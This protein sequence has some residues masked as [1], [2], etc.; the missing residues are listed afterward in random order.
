MRTEQKPYQ[1]RDMEAFVSVLY[2]LSATL[3]IDQ[4]TNPFLAVSINDVLLI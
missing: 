4:L 1:L 3:N 2:D